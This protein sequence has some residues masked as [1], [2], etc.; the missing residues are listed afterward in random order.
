MSDLDTDLDDFYVP[1]SFRPVQQ[2]MWQSTPKPHVYNHKKSASQ[3]REGL[4][5]PPIFDRDAILKQ[6][7]AQIAEVQQN[8]TITEQQ[9]PSIPS[10][11]YS[12]L[13]SR[14]VKSKL[15]PSLMDKLGTCRKFGGYPR[16]NAA[17][18]LA[19]FESFARLHELDEEDEARKLAAF[20]LHLQGPALTWYSGLVPG[21]TWQNVKE[22]FEF[23]Y[24]QIGWQHPSVVI[25]NETFQ[26]IQLYPHQEI[27]DYYCQLI[28][29]GQ[30][31]GKN[32]HEIMYKFINGLPEKL[33][34]YVRTSN[35]KDTAEALSMAKAGE[36]YKYRIHDTVSTAKPN[37]LPRDTDVTDLKSQ[38]DD[39]TTSKTA[40]Y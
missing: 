3:P 12:N 38:V 30:I 21:L 22:G 19:E 17:K 16:E 27:E 36:A 29:K 35:P 33:A 23:K 13:T 24:V 18:F 31:L 4:Q 40:C 32:D 8:I 1:P 37:T 20:H 2:L 5:F 11:S 34:F 7:D 15:K 39:L 14:P 9:T 6:I 10:P 26:N 25:E 28:E